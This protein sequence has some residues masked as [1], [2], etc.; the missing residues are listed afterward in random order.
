MGKNKKIK[1]LIVDDSSVVRVTLSKIM[2][3]DPDIEVIGTAE[4]PYEAVKIMKY[5]KPDVIALDIIMPKMDGITFLKKVMSQYPIPVVIISSIATKGSDVAFKAFD[6]GAIDIITKPRIDTREF[7]EES[8][9]R[10]CDAIKSAAVAQVERKGI[11][12]LENDSKKQIV[13]KKL[14]LN[15]IKKP[16]KK[17]VV[18]GASAGGV[19]DHPVFSPKFVLTSTLPIRI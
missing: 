10:I 17:I 14:Y 3:L 11:D 12:V 18:I 6:Y 5:I 15:K 16:S 7:I 8:K 19:K 9:I 1:V 13:N 4:N 2:S